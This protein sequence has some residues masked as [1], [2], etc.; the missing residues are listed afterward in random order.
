[1]RS[2][3]R[4]RCRKWKT[5]KDR[6]LR[7]DSIKNLPVEEI[8]SNP[9]ENEKAFND[10]NTFI[11]ESYIFHQELEKKRIEEAKARKYDFE[12]ETDKNQEMEETK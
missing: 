10:I 1:M 2:K 6:S 9:T 8:Q 7:D 11:E 4:R 5:K 3:S 12:E